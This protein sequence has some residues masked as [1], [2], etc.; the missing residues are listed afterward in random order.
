[1]SQNDEHA[2]S[3]CS[4]K[5]TQVSQTQHQREMN[6]QLKYKKKINAIDFK[7]FNSS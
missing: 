5:K 6:W 7:D 2:T 4:A 1:M 3:V